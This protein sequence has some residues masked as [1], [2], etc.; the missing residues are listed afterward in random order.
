MTENRKAEQEALRQVLIEGE[1]PGDLATW[2][3]GG[4]KASSHMLHTSPGLE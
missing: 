1:T 3:P 4:T 2:W